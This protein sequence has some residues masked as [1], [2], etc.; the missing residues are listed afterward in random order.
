[1]AILTQF[2]KP[3]LT[4]V[5][6]QFCGWHGEASEI[7]KALVMNEDSSKYP[8]DTCPDCMRNGGLIY[9]DTVK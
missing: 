4:G 7:F 8:I 3:K 1:M 9:H 5:T 6:C 2:Y